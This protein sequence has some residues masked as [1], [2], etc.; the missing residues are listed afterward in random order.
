MVKF[1]HL[2]LLSVLIIWLIGSGCVGKDAAEVNKSETQGNLEAKAQPTENLETGLTQTEIQ[3]L[4]SDMADLEYLLE[5]A[6]LQDDI[7]IEEL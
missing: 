4:D 1:S 7:Q 3:E 2:L 6:S 5:N